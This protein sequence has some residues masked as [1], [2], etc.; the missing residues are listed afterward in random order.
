[1]L[2]A[3]GRGALRS[4]WVGSVSGMETDAHRSGF[5]VARPH[6][7]NV[8]RSL[9]RPPSETDF[10]MTIIVERSFCLLHHLGDGHEMMTVSAVFRDQPIHRFHCS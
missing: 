1:M 7:H 4:D 2:Q 6:R 9:C 8:V 3:G 5:G 10:G